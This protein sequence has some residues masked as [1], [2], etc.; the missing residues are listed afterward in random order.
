MT[1]ET[2]HWASVG[3]VALQAPSDQEGLKF[4][5]NLPD[6][7]VYVCMDV[8]VCV[9]M[10]VY[11]CV[12]MCVCMCVYVRVCVCEITNAINLCIADAVTSV[13][14]KQK[15]DYQSITPMNSSF[16]YGEVRRANI[17]QKNNL[18]QAKGPCLR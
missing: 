12:C 18:Y 16:Q 6:V 5:C 8:C 13:H 17:Q 2:A 1:G 11:V 7:C 10:C 14:C 4:A 9:C 15:I 3:G